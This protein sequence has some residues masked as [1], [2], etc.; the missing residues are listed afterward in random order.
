MAIIECVPNFSEGRDP[1][2]IRQIIEAIGSEQ[3]LKI[4]HVDM[5]ASANRTVV[6]FAGA[7][8][9]VVAGA[10]KGILRAS[11]LVD[12]EKH[13]GAHPRL[14]ATDVCPLVPVSGISMEETVKWARSLGKR[15]GEELNIPVYLYE[16]AATCSNRANLAE[17]RAGGYEKL[18]AKLSH[19]DWQ[20]DFGKK[21]FNK[22][23]GATV[24]GARDFLLAYNVNLDTA[25]VSV[26]KAIAAEVRASGRVKKIKGQIQYDQEMKPLRI[27]GL[28]PF[29]KALGWFMEEYKIAQVSMNLVDLKKTP[30]HI[31]FETV[32][33][34]A[35]K[36]GVEV[37]GSEIIGLVPLQSMLEAGRYFFEKRKEQAP[38]TESLLIEEAISSLGLDTL[39]PF[40][41]REKIL[42]YALAKTTS[43][44]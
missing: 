8:A 13:Q 41:P 28:L 37:T 15:V 7:P 25:T 19:P 18:A 21:I 9:A 43:K 33:Q 44:L 4:L 39:R 36:K 6:T 3:E 34:L 42:E 35:L 16:K 29:T 24:I 12:M 40:D 32:R 14:G 26:A 22:R 10:F 17:I 20:P 31:A 2:I 38:K 30:M 5:G 1:A 27:P 11:Q 23:T